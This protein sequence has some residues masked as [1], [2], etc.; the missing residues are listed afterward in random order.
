MVRNSKIL[1][2]GGTGFLGSNLI[3]ELV[4]N[5]NEVISISKKE[6]KLAKLKN[7]TY[8]Y[9]DLKEPLKKYLSLYQI[10]YL[11]NCSVIDH[12]E[13]RKWRAK[14]SLTMCNQFIY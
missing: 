3:S 13:F 7:D 10:D 12:R 14:F 2:A 8:L 9:H 6:L 5:G 11:I 1:V 4:S